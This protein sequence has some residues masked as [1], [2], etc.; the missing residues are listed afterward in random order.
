[1]RLPARR[2]VWMFAVLLLAVVACGRP[3]SDSVGADDVGAGQEDIDVP[4]I[5][6]DLRLTE[7]SEECVKERT[8]LTQ[9]ERYRIAGELREGDLA[10]LYH[11]VDL[12]CLIREGVEV[13]AVYRSSILDDNGVLRVLAQCVVSDHAWS[14]SE[15]ILD[16]VGGAVAPDVG[17]AEK[18]RALVACG[19]EEPETLDDDPFANG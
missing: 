11:S 13:P 17:P 5:D 2:L 6:V 10:P 4:P 7:S 16:G 14:R 9:I 8:G 1:M 19:F 18:M 3:V 12:A 15:D